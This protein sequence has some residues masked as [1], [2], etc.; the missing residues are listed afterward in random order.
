[1]A[2]VGS[3]AVRDVA[4][5]WRVDEAWWGEALDSGLRPIASDA[6]DALLDDGTL[7]RIVHERG[8]WYLCGV[9]D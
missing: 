2:S 5:P 1:P 4:G 3:R 8:A 9:Y 6:Y 7:C